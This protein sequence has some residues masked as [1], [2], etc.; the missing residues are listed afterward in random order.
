MK[1]IILLISL[2][3]LVLLFTG[4]TGPKQMLNIISGSENK[5]LEPLIK[6]YASKNNIDIVMHYK[7]SVDMMQMMQT[8]QIL[9]YD[10]VWPANSLWI[11]LGDSAKR[12]DHERS[13][14]TSPI[15]FGI[16][17]SVADS[18][19]Y[20]GRDVY[21][22]D[23]LA[24]I[25]DKK[26][27]FV[28][29]SATQSNSGACAYLGFLSA[30]SGD[31]QPLSLDDLNNPAIQDNLR[32]LLAGVNRSSG[33]SGWL[34]ELYLAGDYQAM[35]N[36]EALVIETN[37]VLIEQGRE[38]L[39]AVYPVDGLSVA[40]SPLGYVDQ[41]NADKER[42]F[43]DFQAYLLSDN[44]QAKIT[45][46]GRRT[47][48]AGVQNK[49][50]NTVFNPNWGIDGNKTI[51]GIT[52]PAADVIRAALSA[53]QTNL[54]KPSYTVY[55]LDYSGSM[56]GDGLS[57]LKAAMATLL[58]QKKASEHLIQAAPDD[59]TQVIAFNH[60]IISTWSV[61]GNQQGNFDALLQEIERLEADGGTDIYRPALTAIDILKSVDANRYNRA[62]VLLTDGI[63]NDGYDYRYF[64]Q[65]FNDYQVDIPVFSI[66]FGSADEAQL[67]E[68]ATLTRARI[69]DGHD[70]LI[71]AF[72]KAK[73]YN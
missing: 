67:K 60:G 64:E 12:I 23:I 2:L 49:I 24:A 13:I 14:M 68:I 73:G 25:N 70:D 17:K 7:G 57:Q 58:D 32:A 20:V 3:L 6:E 47:G 56:A 69:F 22:A 71:A 37:Q 16:R 66:A 62:V 4:C 33:S 31:A 45:R 35:V 43:L 15:V 38:P 55:C 65:S 39:Y 21:V 18:L 8:D 42:A 53:Y 59:I 10:A 41:G 1:K 29:T 44:V 46:L 5:T 11:S 27:S 28:M 50:D 9:D 61:T 26:L 72:K 63:S 51:S 19:G 54:R 52:M 34:K 30:M 48:I 36:Y 40:D